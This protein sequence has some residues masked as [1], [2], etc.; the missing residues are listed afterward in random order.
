MSEVQLPGQAPTL[1]GTDTQRLGRRRAPTLSAARSLWLLAPVS[2][3]AAALSLGALEGCAVKP[4]PQARNVI[5]VPVR[6][7]FA[8][9]QPQ[10]DGKVRDQWVRNFNDPTLDALVREALLN[11]L[12]LRIASARLEEARARAR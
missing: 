1:S 10:N 5:P 12:D 4:V 3:F 2:A 7:T 8:A 11:N 6:E 9:T